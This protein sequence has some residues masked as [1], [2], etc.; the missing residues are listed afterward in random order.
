MKP[1]VVLDEE[2]FTLGFFTSN[3]PE[4][5][6]NKFLQE[7]IGNDGYVLQEKI[8]LPAR[9]STNAA[10]FSACS[11]AAGRC[12]PPL[13]F[14]SHNSLPPQYTSLVARPKSPR[15]IIHKQDAAI[16]VTAPE[17][18]LL[19]SAPLL[20][21][22]EKTVES[23]SAVFDKT[24]DILR[25]CKMAEMHVAR[26]WIYLDDILGDY[27]ILNNA[28]EAFF[29]RWYSAANHF[30][31]AS[32]GIE[33]HV[34]PPAPLALRFCAFS[35]KDIS[36]K[37]QTSPLQN[38]ATEYGKLFSRCV[39]VGLPQ[40]QL[41]Y[42]S[43]TASIDKS[44]ASV[45]TGNFTRQMEFTLEILAAILKEVNGDFSHTA[46]ATVY[47][48]NHQDIDACRKI[49]DKSGFPASRALF[50]LDH[51]VCRDDL[52]CEIELTAVIRR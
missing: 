45:Y 43:G 25:S 50:Q 27:E 13:I 32:T 7:T 2:D 14:T 21:K 29:A 34:I 36:I 15:T 8:I 40:N 47:L 39:V 26:T 30:I 42:I 24:S 28:R 1:D 3:Y 19:F 46:Q 37:Q 10:L 16:K 49:L 52:L 5:D 4:I 48:K 6:H 33:G 18:N 20:S 23:F 44:G 51:H 38:E 31:P 35:G 17:T 22:T 11:I 9:L 41:V 12:N